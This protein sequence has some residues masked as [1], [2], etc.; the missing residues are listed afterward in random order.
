VR[1]A[2]VLVGLGMAWP[3]WGADSPREKARLLG[4]TAT[5]LARDGKYAEAA[6]LYE[7]A[8]AVDPDA[9]LLFN[10]G[11]VL[12]KQ[13]DL[14]RARDFL[15][16][17]LDAEKDPKLKEKGALRLA[18]VLAKL[19]R[20]RVEVDVVGAGVS[21][22]GTLRGETPLAPVDLAE[23]RHRVVVSHVGYEAVERE[24]EV[25]GGVET[26]LNVTLVPAPPPLPP[27]AVVAPDPSL[28]PP[29]AVPV[30]DALAAAEPAP[31]SVSLATAA[32]ESGRP[33]RFTW[34][35]V[36]ASSGAAI[37]VGG[38]VLSWLAQSDRAAVSD[39]RASG[40]VVTSMTQRRADELEDR[41]NR[42][43]VGSWVLYGVGAA[44][45][46]TGVTLLLWPDDPTP[47]SAFA[48]PVPGGAVVGL[49]ASF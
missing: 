34:G 10:L 31:E 12:E 11:V 22:D 47:A 5:M 48:V 39:A 21:I 13:G 44:A 18:K 33:P 45:V 32:V 38:G 24:V 17:Y 41:A 40:G 1:A 28:A 16:R 43:T 15:Q 20:V 7:Q 35:V 30:D 25:R 9:I 19:G 8:Y 3:A 4:K 46:V 26:P 42:F 37:A 49:G 14:P 2:I 23:G 6:A 27:V 36:A 29:P